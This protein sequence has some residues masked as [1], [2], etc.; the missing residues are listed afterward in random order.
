MR[1]LEFTF[2]VFKA[3]KREITSD[4]ESKVHKMEKYIQVIEQHKIVPSKSKI[5]QVGETSTNKVEETDIKKPITQVFSPHN[6]YFTVPIFQQVTNQFF[7][8]YPEEEYI[9]QQ[10]M[11]LCMKL[12]YSLLLD[13]LYIYIYSFVCF[14]YIWIMVI[15]LFRCISDPFLVIVMLSVT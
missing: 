11:I 13:Y 14:C 2:S 7:T 12:I 6:S 3:S 1:A 5:A 4:F 10:G 9:K 8:S 15:F